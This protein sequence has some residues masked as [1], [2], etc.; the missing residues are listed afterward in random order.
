MVEETKLKSHETIQC[1]AI[2]DFQVFYLSRQKSQ[3]GGV[4]L[5]VNKIFESTL[6][7][8][9]DDE[10]EVISVLVVVGDIEIRVIVGY[11]PQENA[12]REKKEKFWDFI[13]NEVVQADSEHQGVIIQ[14]DGN[15]HAGEELLKD[16]PN[17]Q[18]QNGKF[19]M[20]F[21]R[22]N[23]MLSVVNTQDICEGLITRQRSLQTRSEKSVLD[24]FLVNEK[25]NPFLKK[26]IVDEKREFS[27]GNY[28]QFHTNK[29]VIESDH[30]G[31]ILELALEYSA[32]KPERK[33]FF[34]FR[35]KV[36][37][38]AFKRETETNRQLLE[39]FDNELSVEMQSKM[40]LRTF[41]SI[42][43]KCFKKIR[44][45]KK[46]RE[47]VGDKNSL[48]RERINLIKNAK[49][50]NISEALKKQIEERIKQIENA[51]GNDIVNEYHEEI[52]ET[53]KD[54]GG[55]QTTIDGSGRQKLWK[56]LKRK[57]PKIKSNIPIGKKDRKGNL[58]TNH[59]GLKNLYLKTYKQ[60]LRNRPMRTGF[61][62]IENLKN[63]LF[64]LR[65]E[66]C[67]KTKSE[68]WEMHHLEKAIKTLKKDKARDP[69]GWINDL[70]REDVAGFNLKLSMLKLFNK[71]K[72]ENFIPSFMRKADI[73]TLY[74]GKGSKSDLNNDRGIF[75]CIH[76]P[77]P[78][79]ENDL[80]RYL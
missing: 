67:E 33:E 29:R 17:P 66:L 69:N 55:D 52:L 31:L 10:T 60:R 47:N 18:N 74:K 37:Q 3:G 51:I 22:R 46:N 12:L 38:E 27:L 28:A 36:C 26:M 42:I 63:M 2:S 7:N 53:I 35:N 9:G 43:F 49:S 78:A 1:E 15:L 5:G 79:N 68:E 80:S 21:L 39:C 76:F 64:D 75:Y 23:S 56:I 32:Q 19:F 14:I 50:K 58:I 59:L 41:N 72:N 65:K 54:L 6:L 45:G 77:K 57:N 61:E 16:D 44:M 62:E 30:N 20:D 40:W 11:G 13:E 4:A 70:F 8:E 25:L 34:N 48:L 24:F 73:T 71:I